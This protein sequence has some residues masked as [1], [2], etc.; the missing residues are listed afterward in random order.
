[1]STIKNRNYLIDN[2]RFL[3]IFC[4]VF[5]HCCEMFEPAH[6]SLKYVIFIIYLFHVPGLVFISGYCTKK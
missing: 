2:F 5:A 4:V 6:E 3:M 1:M